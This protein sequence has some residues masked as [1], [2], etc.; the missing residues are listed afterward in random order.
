MQRIVAHYLFSKPCLSQ[1]L[2]CTVSSTF[3]EQMKT[4]KVQQVEK[5]LFQGQAA[6]REKLAQSKASAKRGMRLQFRRFHVF[7]LRIRVSYRDSPYQPSINPRPYVQLQHDRWCR[8]APTLHSRQERRQKRRR[9]RGSSRGKLSSARSEISRGVACK[10]CRFFDVNGCRRGK[11]VNWP[12][13]CLTKT[14]KTTTAE[15][16]V[17]VPLDLIAH[18]ECCRG[19]LLFEETLGVRVC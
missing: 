13:L 12:R 5:A 2:T 7:T 14:H 1:S 19:S 15:R 8:G 6:L 11:P 18:K 9:R 3:L 17:V 10:V 16:G 4:N